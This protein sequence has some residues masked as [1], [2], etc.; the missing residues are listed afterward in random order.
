MPLRQYFSTA[1]VT[2]GFVNESYTVNEADGTALVT[3]AV[4]SGELSEDV[5]VG[6]N[7]QDISATGVCARYGVT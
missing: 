5:V 1:G 6:F 2:I 4:L 3:V 7:T